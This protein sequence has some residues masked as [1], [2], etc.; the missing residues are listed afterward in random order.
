MQQKTLLPKSFQDNFNEFVKMENEG[1]KTYEDLLSVF[2][3][4]DGVS[5]GNYR[6]RYIREQ[7]FLENDT[8]GE[9]LNMRL[10]TL[11]LEDGNSQYDF[12]TTINVKQHALARDFE[13]EAKCFSIT[14]Y[15]NIVKYI[16][17]RIGYLK[18]QVEQRGLTISK[19]WSW[20]T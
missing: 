16:H 3:S 10:I 18:F 12:K 17:L 7:L 19:G 5:I 6:L 2:Q 11:Y 13:S 15:D 4:L 14:D 20:S 8:L 1:K 9:V